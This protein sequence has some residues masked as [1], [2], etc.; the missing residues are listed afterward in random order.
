[1]SYEEI[2]AQLGMK[3]GS[4]G[5]TRQRILLRLRRADVWL[6]YEPTF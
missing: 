2:S 3:R 4:I 1:V 6:D 5:P